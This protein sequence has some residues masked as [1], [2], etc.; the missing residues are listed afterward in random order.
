MNCAPRQKLPLSEVA[1]RREEE[2]SKG[3][4]VID[5]PDGSVSELTYSILSART[6]IADHTGVSPAFAGE[7]FG[8][9]LV[10][11]LMKDAKAEGFEVIPLC[12]YVNAQRRRH[13]EWADLFQV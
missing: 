6:V 13:P 1:V 11:A 5:H 9:V 8:K 3:R 7:G 2:G 10:E 4:Y 12:P